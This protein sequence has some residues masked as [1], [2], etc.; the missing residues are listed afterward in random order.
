MT[1]I[2][3]TNIIARTVLAPVERWRIIKQTQ[4]TYPLRPLT[5]KNAI[6][7]VS[8]KWL[9][10]LGIPKE[11]GFSAFWRGNMPGL[12]LYMTQSA[13]QVGLYDNLKNLQKDLVS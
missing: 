5:F 11:Q 4:T 7:Y 1:E 12:W 10:I 6:D 13:I 9:V 3:L 2:G 8:S